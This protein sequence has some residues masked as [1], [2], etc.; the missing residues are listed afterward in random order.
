MTPKLK[1]TLFKSLLLLIPVSTLMMACASS[2]DK[3][4][5]PDEYSNLVQLTPPEIENPEES[6][7][8][9]DSAKVI[10]SDNT[11]VL[12]IT[13]SFPDGCTRVGTADHATRD[14]ILVLEIGAWRDPDMMC[15]QALVEFSFIYRDID[16]ERL[17]HSD[18]VRINGKTYHLKTR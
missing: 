1:L 12:L 17:R 5:T 16:P 2:Q 8:Y 18:S 10:H 3:S 4:P 11:P 13:G 15:T 7:I 14:N 9:V 6:K